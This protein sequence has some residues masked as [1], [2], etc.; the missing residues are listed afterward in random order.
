MSRD[1]PTLI[2]RIPG[3]VWFFAGMLIASLAVGILLAIAHHGLTREAPPPPLPIG[4]VAHT[5][6]E[7]AVCPEVPITTSL[8]HAVACDD[9][10]AANRLLSA[11]ANPDQIDTRAHWTGRTALHHAALTGNESA[12]DMLLAAGASPDAADAEGNT[13]L[14]VLPRAHDPVVAVAI[15]KRLL[16][17]GAGVDTPNQAGRSPLQMLESD[18]PRLIEHQALAQLLH[19]TTKAAADTALAM[20]ETTL[21]EA[22]SAAGAP[23]PPAAPEAVSSAPPEAPPADIVATAADAPAGDEPAPQARRDIR[24]TLQAWTMAWSGKDMDNYLAQYH[25]DFSPGDGIDRDRWAQQ[26]HQRIAGKP[27]RIT[28]FLRDIEIEV[29]GDT[30]TA[31][32]TQDYASGNYQDSTRKRLS[33]ARAGDRWQILDESSID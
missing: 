10:P 29:R 6:S 23:P 24:S 7:H 8:P 16:G 14:H 11:G 28:V 22:P 19:R 27:G 3:M 18:P 1:T 12:A 26:R 32:F 9:L 33:L 2:D 15:A 13:P 5:T 21:T 17:A 25:A 30:A 31:T 20:A 4:K